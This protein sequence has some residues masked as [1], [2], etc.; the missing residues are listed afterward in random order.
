MG[1][2]MKKKI[3]IIIAVLLAVS[4][5]GCNVLPKITDFS[6]SSST[7]TK[8]NMGK[9]ITLPKAAGKVT[10]SSIP[11]GDFDYSNQFNGYQNVSVDRI[12]PQVEQKI[13]TTKILKIDKSIPKI[14][15]KIR[16]KYKFTTVNPNQYY[17]Y[18][19]LNSKGK[20]IY[21]VIDKGVA[22]GQ[23]YINILKYKANYLDLSKIYY[24]FYI[25]H[26]EY[27]WVSKRIS[28]TIDPLNNTVCQIVLPFTDGTK[29]DKFD[30]EG[31]LVPGNIADRK[32]ISQQISE[33]NSAVALVVNSVPEKSQFEKEKFMHDYIGNNT[34]YSDITA[35]RF[36]NNNLSIEYDY[37]FS[38]YG[39]L[40]NH[41]A[42]CEGYAKAF[43]FLCYLTG[44]NVT[45]VTGTSKD[46]PHM[47][48]AVCI[49]N[50]WYQVDVTW[51][52]SAGEVL[53]YQY[54]NV[55]D[56]EIKVDHNI[57]TYYFDYPV[58]NSTD[59]SYR[60]FVIC[61]SEGKLPDNAND[62]IKYAVSHLENYI[63]IKVCDTVSDEAFPKILHE[64]E[65]SIAN[66]LIIINPKFNVTGKV[67]SLGKDYYYME[68]QNIE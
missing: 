29:T 2:N 34:L 48:N 47:W 59:D 31:K 53:G 10:E 37:T 58:C 57:K 28:F 50:K 4:M 23:N 42:V 40:V 60:Q 14:S 22:N 61:I 46:I 8:T 43:Q 56:S 24:S 1:D 62:V 26:P 7:Q 51:D 27:F 35:Q 33:F 49:N 55:T 30:F 18:T 68:I 20:N 65:D 19:K 44:I 11:D 41:L 16:K 25:D 15:T 45:S 32:V 39:V 5:C 6:V 36:I 52:D 54:F 12:T 38:V 9:N 63:I 13:P 3:E 67:M 66:R 64:N 21:N 17:G